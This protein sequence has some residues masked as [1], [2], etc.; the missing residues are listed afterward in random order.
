MRYRRTMHLAIAIAALLAVSPR[1]AF[2]DAYDNVKGGDWYIGVDNETADLAWGES[3]VLWSLM[4][5]VRSTGHPRYVDRL[6]R[7]L[8]ALL[9]QRDDSRGVTD[10]R[11]VAGACWRNTSYQKMGEP[12]CYAVHSGMLIYPMAELAAFIAKW[13]HRDALAYDGQSFAAKAAVYTQAAIATAAYHDDE[14]NDAGYYIFRGDAVFL[15]Y[16]GVDQPLN[17]SN[18]M[19]LALLALHDATGDPLYLARATA[20]ATRL[21]A[22][23]TPGPGGGLVWNYWGGPYAAPGEDISHAALN[24]EFAVQ[25]AARGLVFGD[26]DL[27]A[28]AAT[29]L[30]SVYLDDQSF[31]DFIGGG[32]VN[33]DGYRPQIGRWLPLTRRRAALYAAVHDA[34]QRD[35]PAAAVGSGSLLLAWAYLAE[36][37]PRVC[38]HFFY[39]HDWQDLGDAMQATAYGANVLTVPPVLTTACRI[40][41]SVQATRRVVAAQWDGADMHRVAEW[42]PGPDFAARSVAYEPRWPLV[43]FEDGV[44]FEFQ[45]DFAADE[46]VRVQ[47]PAIG[48]LPAITSSP[49]TA[50]ELAVP[51]KY[52][53]TGAGSPPFWWSLRDG[54][55]GLAVDPATGVVEFT[56]QVPGEWMFRLALENDLGEAEQTFVV[57][58]PAAMTGSTGD[59]PTSSGDT[60]DPPPGTATSDDP[61]A[62]ATG[63][64]SDTSGA[65]TPDAPADADAGCGCRSD[66]QPARS[67]LALLALL[68]LLRRRRRPRALPSLAAL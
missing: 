45:D 9:A 40:P 1:W 62:T 67:E 34:Y 15:E 44:L 41:L 8:D 51:L 26:A 14:W 24:V 6:A 22:M 28:I 52:T 55:D 57:H 29:F 4:A 66:P 30:T 18:A 64:T 35:Y 58:V 25:A 48:T 13:R 3:Y 46:A 53:P 5:M 12:Y 65:T 36:F 61:P 60:G 33:G 50:A 10:Y 17:Q 7:H 42:Q 54:P 19:G 11:G 59:A 27:D 2:E 49:P 47:K 23:M 31:A 20:L 21:R 43:Y 32:T 16:A 38:P 63:D 56:P 39:P 68:A 37:E